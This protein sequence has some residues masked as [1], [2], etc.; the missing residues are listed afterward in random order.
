MGGAE[1]GVVNFA[2]TVSEKFTGE[3][4]QGEPLG[5]LSSSSVKKAVCFKE[6]RE[7]VQNNREGEGMLH[8]G[9][10]AVLGTLQE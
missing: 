2:V 5:R 3:E 8:S 6:K 10:A 1:K 7:R 9:G 4:S